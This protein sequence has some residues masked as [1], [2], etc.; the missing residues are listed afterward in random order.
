M[1]IHPT[2]IIA[3]RAILGR[4]VTIGPWVLVEDDVV[5][6]DGTRI[7]AHAVIYS[8][9]RIGRDCHIFQSASVG[10]IPQDLKFH[11]EETTLQ[12]GDRT[13]IREFATL[14]RGTE[15]S[16]TT[17]VGSDVLI[18]N[19]VHVAHDCVVGDHV[20]LANSVNLAGHC[21]LGDW[22]I[23]GGMVPVHQFVAIGDHAF[24]GGG[25][26]VTKDVPP[27]V[28]AAGDPLRYT[29]PNVMGLERR[30]F[31]PERISR[32]KGWYRQVFGGKG[33]LSAVID[34]ITKE[35]GADEDRE[36][37]LNFL[38]QSERGII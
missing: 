37:I 7:D 26:K 32:I 34:T 13:R 3:D 9:T 35:T 2:A 24:I 29:R 27:F 11:G 30:G 36:L 33:T 15:E 23:I 18:M 1:S 6:G 20:I 16:G 4:N 5:I 10:A 12:I 22:V 38:R 28:L 8:G 25:C 31:S 14:H 17:R 21:K 19:Y